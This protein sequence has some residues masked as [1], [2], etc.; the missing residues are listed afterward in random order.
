MICAGGATGGHLYPALAVAD[1]LR[2]RNPEIEI[3]FIGAQKEVGSDIVKNA[4]YELMT[5]PARGFNRKNP[6]KN[7]S[8]ARDLLASS[9]QTAH[10]LKTFQPDA[11]FGSGGYVCGP[12]IRAAHQ[13][14]IPT[15][16]H[17]QN[18]IPGVA[19]RLAE[20]YADTVFI[21]FEE[22]RASFKNPDKIV[23]T[24]NPV[25]K[26][27]LT[28]GVMHYRDRLGVN[29]RDMALLIF[30]GSLGATKI[31]EVAADALIALKDKQDVTVFFITG[32]S[33]YAEIRGKLEAAGVTANPKVHVMEYTDRIHEYYSAA[34]LIISRSGA[35]TVSEIAVC[36][37]ASLLIP[38]PN[39]TGNHQYFN[40]K[41]L[42][43]K[44]AA[45]IMDEADL[46]AESLTDEI[47]KLAANKELLNRMGEAAAK[48]GRPD[49]TDV[50]ADAI[51]GALTHEA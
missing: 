5:I 13:Q 43:D 2:R 50:I 39:V 29:P 23:V 4:G 41:T 3:L 30:G 44:G 9:R 47:R 48:Q 35:L 1:K 8:V 6:F 42:A 27:F 7:I 31:N 33:G 22:S 17:E 18:V 45:V 32:R 49:A 37:K 12:V 38:S 24:G 20:K 14:H 51:Q 15:F 21:A 11:V 40:A 34:D 10:I 46:T 16:L 26:Q 25:R 28:A 36:G 19:N